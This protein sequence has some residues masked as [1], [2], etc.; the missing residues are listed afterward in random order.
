MEE[1]GGRRAEKEP[2]GEFRGHLDEA[3]PPVVQEEVDHGLLLLPAVRLPELPS[4]VATDKRGARCLPIWPLS[5]ELV[6]LGCRIFDRD[7]LQFLL[8]DLQDIFTPSPAVINF[9]TCQGQGQDS[10]S[11]V[12]A[13]SGRLCSLPPAPAPLPV[14][15]SSTSLSKSLGRPC[16]TTTTSWGS[17]RS[18]TRRSTCSLV[19]LG[20]VRRN[21]STLRLVTS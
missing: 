15:T 10:G 21:S 14:L 18:A 5:P 20:E 17:G 19:R 7:E 1:G 12:P 6:R 16:S 4:E 2:V 13:P 9:C 11:V 3:E 8:G